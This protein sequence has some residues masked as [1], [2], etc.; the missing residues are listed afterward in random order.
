MK[1]VDACIDSEK[2]KNSGIANEHLKNL[3][4]KIAQM[5][6]L[7]T[8]ALKKLKIYNE[9]IA[10]LKVTEGQHCPILLDTLAL[11]TEEA[12]GIED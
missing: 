9:G 4:D 3:D 8:E 12:K 5:N 6:A 2:A 11:L 10:E 7:K 1:D